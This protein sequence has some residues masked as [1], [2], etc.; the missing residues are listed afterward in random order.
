VLVLTVRMFD[1]YLNEFGEKKVLKDIVYM[2]K[3][4]ASVLLKLIMNGNERDATQ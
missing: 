4:A 3:I 2:G 1:V